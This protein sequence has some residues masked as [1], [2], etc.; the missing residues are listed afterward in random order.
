MQRPFLPFIPGLLACALALVGSGCIRPAAQA[1]VSRAMTPD[2]MFAEPCGA[3]MWRPD[4]LDRR[5]Q[6]LADADLPARHRILRPGSLIADDIDQ[7]RL[8]VTVNGKGK[9]DGVFCG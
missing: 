6:V 2:L 7:M 5:A 9:V 1:P 4:L 8:T 3:A